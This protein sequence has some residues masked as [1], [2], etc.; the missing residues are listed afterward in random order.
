MTDQQAVF[1]IEKIYVRD[2]SIEVPNAPAIF[3]EREAPAIGV[4]IQTA[5]TNVGEGNFEV[6][7]TITVTAKKEEKVFFLVEVAQAGIFQIRNVPDQEMQPILAIGCPNILFPYARESISDA[8]N[9]AGFPPVL[10][11]P[12]NFEAL[13]QQSEQAADAAPAQLQ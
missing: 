5:A 12:V 13:Y 1:S 4:Q 7:V 6:V 2:L 11:A 3:L 8:I 9:R 10:L